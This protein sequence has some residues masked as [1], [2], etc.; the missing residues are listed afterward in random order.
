MTVQEAKIAINEYMNF[1]NC[2]RMH[3][4]LEYKTPE[5]VYYE[6]KSQKVA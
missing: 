6:N 3:Q 1:Y 5:L 2:H 4:A